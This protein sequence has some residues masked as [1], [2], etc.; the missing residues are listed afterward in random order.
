MQFIM[1]IPP[2]KQRDEAYE[3]E[4]MAKLSE[5]ERSEGER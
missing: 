3:N 5:A 1:S 4:Q 2:D